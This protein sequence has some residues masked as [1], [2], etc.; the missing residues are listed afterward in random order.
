[1]NRGEGSV[2]GHHKM[3]FNIRPNLKSKEFVFV[4]LYVW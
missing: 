1:M 3:L 2:I 4:S